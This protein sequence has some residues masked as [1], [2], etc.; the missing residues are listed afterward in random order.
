M[1][2]LDLVEDE[3]GLLILAALEPG[4]GG[5]VERVDVAGDVAGIGL[6]P[7]SAKGVA[8]G[9]RRAEVCH[10]TS[11]LTRRSRLNAS[12]LAR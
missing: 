8:A 2:A 4:P 7:V 3:G 11:R 12:T 6:R 5:I 10:S 9:E 1:L